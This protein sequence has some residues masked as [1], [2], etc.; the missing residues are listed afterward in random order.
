MSGLRNPVKAARG[1]AAAALSMEALA[2]LLAIAPM[3]MLLDDS[4]GA[5]T[6][7]LVLLVGC[8]VLA[9]RAGKPWVWK[10]G[11][12]LQVV[13]ILCAVFHVS[14][15]IAGIVFALTWAFCWKVAREL[16]RPPQRDESNPDYSP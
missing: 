2:I 3:R 13:F 12:V 5:I 9:S 11:M 1:L 10:A 4:T 15:G 6:A 7:L 14:L 8:V 16:S